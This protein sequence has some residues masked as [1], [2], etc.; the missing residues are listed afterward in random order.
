MKSVLRVLHVVTHMNKGG[1]ETMIMN[2]YRSI[3]R[4]LVQFDF[5]THRPETEQKDYDYEISQMGG[6]IY[7]IPRLNPFSHKYRKALSAFLKKHKEYNIIH[8]HLDCMSGIVLKQ[9]KLAGLKC[10]IGHCHSSS[11]DKN[12]YYV[13]K[14]LFKR[15]ISK[16]ATHL[17]ACGESS[18]KWMFGR[19]SNF[20]ILNN[21]IDSNKYA[22]NFQRRQMI[23][24]EFG[25]DDKCI[26]VGLVARFSK[27]KNHSFLVR[28]FEELKKKYDN[29]LLVLVG[30]GER[31]QDIKALVKEKELTNSVLF[32]GLR[33]DVDFVLQGF[34][35]F[36]MPSLYE[37]LP[38]SVIESQA[39]STKT[40]V[41]TNVPSECVVTNLVRRIGLND[42]PEKWAELI[43]SEYPYTKIDRR[44]E[45]KK[46]GFDISESAKRLQ[47]F[48]LEN[49]N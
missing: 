43:L 49:N 32:L 30:Q 2:Y 6:K 40:I 36:V 33:D 44:I 4:N 8:V 28:V 15:L 11:Q 23:R 17:F 41:S 38:L 9:A 5:L 24:K 20:T 12:L 29:S 13:I 18:G 37:G 34:D 45:I 21:A 47:S 35:F 3:D 19:D 31:E 22:F 1:L 10:R 26:V 25:A 42:H 14:L 39:S 48:Y 27:V 16:Y 46:S 7:H